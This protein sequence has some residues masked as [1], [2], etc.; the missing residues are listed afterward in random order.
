MGH[1][2][3]DHH[4]LFYEPIIGAAGNAPF[5]VSLLLSVGGAWGGTLRFTKRSSRLLATGVC[6][7]LIFAAQYGAIALEVSHRLCPNV[8]DRDSCLARGDDMIATLMFG[9]VTWLFSIV[10]VVTI[11]L[12]VGQLWLDMALDIARRILNR[13]R[14]SPPQ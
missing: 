9:G 1:W 11:I 14:S 6:T 5:T 2:L 7:V 13:G 12:I 3:A 8:T 10:L 4:V